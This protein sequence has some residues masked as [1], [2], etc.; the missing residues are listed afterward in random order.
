[1]TTNSSVGARVG[2]FSSTQSYE[3]QVYQRCHPFWMSPAIRNLM[4]TCNFY[5]PTIRTMRPG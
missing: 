3:M 5:F 2:T 1:V 4:V